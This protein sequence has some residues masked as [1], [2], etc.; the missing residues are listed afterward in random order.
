MSQDPHRPVRACIFDMDGLLINSEDIITDC[1]NEILHEYGKPPLPWS[2]KAQLQ[3]RTLQDASQVLLSWA[4]L[5][6]SM[7]EYQRQ[8]K[9]LHQKYFPTTQP[10]PGV[11]DLLAKLGADQ[12]IELALATS[13]NREKFALKTDHLHDLFAVFPLSRRVL[14]DDPRILPGRH[15]P[16]PDIYALALQ[17]INDDLAAKRQAQILPEECL[18]FEDSLQGVEA[19]VQAGMRVIWCPHPALVEE[20]KRQEDPTLSHDSSHLSRRYDERSVQVVMTLSD[21]NT[22]SHGIE[23]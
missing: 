15:K 7:E 17:C 4:Q 6:I 10:L 22:G 2:I 21:F 12:R 8:L 16:A 11:S 20:M 18:V 19:G 3:G 23:I 5:P 9:T 14:G 13:S 1:I